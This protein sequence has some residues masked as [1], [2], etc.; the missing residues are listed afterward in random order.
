MNN[1]PDI[2]PPGWMDR[3]LEWYCKPELLED[4]QGDLHEYYQRNLSKGRFR[5]NWIYFLDVLKFFRLYLIRKPKRFKRMTFFN[6]FS[7]YFKTSVRS[8][9]RNKLFSAIN[10]VGLAISMSVGLL[11]IVYLSELLSYD[12]FH[13]KAD[14]IY[15][16][17]TDYRSTT[18]EKFGHYASTSLSIGRKLQSDYPGIEKLVVLNRGSLVDLSF[19]DQFHTSRVMW[20]TED[21]FQII[22][23]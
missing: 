6:L 16:V 22:F 23:F 17:Q 14:R 1:R 7:N 20:S 5:A 19:E 9:A 10:V 4:L 15:R 3:L 13:E 8:I 11:M 12:T 2:S 18:D 21:F